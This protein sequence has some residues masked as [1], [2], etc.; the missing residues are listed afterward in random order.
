MPFTKDEGEKPSVQKTIEGAIKN[1]K[2]AWVGTMGVGSGNR[3]VDAANRIAIALLAVR[4]LDFTKG[5]E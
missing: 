5:A 4:L 1:A 2:V 3:E